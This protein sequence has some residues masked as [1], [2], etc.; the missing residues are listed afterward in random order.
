MRQIVA[1]MLS[2]SIKDLPQRNRITQQQVHRRGV[3]RLPKRLAE[4]PIQLAEDVLSESFVVL[5]KRL[6]DERLPDFPR[7]LCPHANELP[8]HGY[9]SPRK[10]LCCSDTQ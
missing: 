2:G 7:S 5:A 3:G 8:A 10:A 9:S 4:L 6:L 1:Y